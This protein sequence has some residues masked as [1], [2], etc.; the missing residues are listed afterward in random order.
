MPTRGDT[1]INNFVKGLVTDA[2]PLSFPPNTSL[3]VINFRLNKDGTN[4]RRLGLDFEEDYVL[5]ATGYS[6]DVLSSARKAYYRWSL[7]N[8][9]PLVDIGVVQI[10]AKFWFLNLYAES[11]STAI[12]NGGLP[13]DAGIDPTARFSFAVLNNYLLVVSNNLPSP[14]LV[15]Y[16]GDTDTITFETSPLLV[17][18]LWGVDDG[19]A[20]DNHPTTLTPAHRYNLLN[21]GW[22][23]SIVTTCGAGINAVDCT[24]ITLGVYPSNSDVWTIGRIGDL[25]S[26]DVEKYDPN[27]AARNIFNA[28]QVAQGH[29]IL[30]LKARGA[31]R[32]AQTGLT[33]PQDAEYGTVSCVAGYAGRAFYSGILSDVQD[34]DAR[35]PILSGTVLFS[36]VFEQKLNLVKC[37]QEAD[38]TSPDISDIVDT[39]GGLIV[40]P[41]CSYITHLRVI[42]ESLFVFAVNG[43]WEIRGDE[44]GFRATAFQVTK[45]SNTGVYSPDSIVEINGQILYWGINGIYALARNQF[46]VFETTS[47]TQNVIQKYYNSIPDFARSQAKGYYDLNNNTVRWLFYSDESKIA[48]Q[49]LDVQPPSPPIAQF[50][51]GEASLLAATPDTNLIRSARIDDTRY[52]IVYKDGSG[53]MALRGVV[54]TVDP[55]TL[56][57]TFGTPVTIHA[58]DTSGGGF[59]L[60]RLDT[61]KILVIHPDGNSPFTTYARVLTISGTS[62]TVGATNDLNENGIGTIRIAVLS[63][64]KAIHSYTESS[65]AKVRELVISGDTVTEGTVTNITSVASAGDLVALNSTQALLVHAG[66]GTGHG[67]CVLTDTAGTISAGTNFNLVT[68]GFQGPNGQDYKVTTNSNGTLVVIQTISITEAPSTVMTRT[69]GISGTTVTSDAASE[70]ITELSV[71]SG[72]DRHWGVAMSDTLDA[73]LAMENDTGTRRLYLTVVSYSSGSISKRYNSTLVSADINGS[74]HLIKLNST[75]AVWCAFKGSSSGDI[76]TGAIT[77]S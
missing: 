61:D 19:I 24:Q 72:T 9:N 28:G 48:G 3:D 58:T 10:G 46:G 51:V 16:N 22:S 30:Q 14:Y 59:D 37:Y 15:S 53:S 5:T 47:I 69:L 6:T 43:V 70:Y 49:V 41:E 39:D 67:A 45:V 4:F 40:I 42:K 74:P 25:T 12:L 66:T 29:Y 56:A 54:C 77:I 75:T 71:L 33:L 17:R 27:I 60:R 64:T 34:G 63:P 36:Q 55:T 57:V 21:Q 62:F 76:L 1:Q 26:A 11:P 73:V 65:Q 13:V 68:N 7:P 50:T 44:G 2:S 38:P 8:G 31:D 32:F 20:V 52:I 23:N 18:D 35:S